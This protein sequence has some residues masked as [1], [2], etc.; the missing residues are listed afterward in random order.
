MTKLDQGTSR[1]ACMELLK[2]VGV[3]SIPGSAFFDGAGGE[4]CARFC[5]AL[6]EERVSLAAERLRKL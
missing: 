4:D 6:K 5:F 2:R 1:E 3:A